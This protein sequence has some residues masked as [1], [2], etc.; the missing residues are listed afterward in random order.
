MLMHLLSLSDIMN[1]RIIN[2]VA[3]AD[4]PTVRSAGNRSVLGLTN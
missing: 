1:A 4:G 2:L 3:L